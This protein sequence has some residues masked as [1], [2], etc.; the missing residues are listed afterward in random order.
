MPK[1]IFELKCN[2]LINKSLFVH[3]AFGKACVKCKFTCHQIV[4]FW[5]ALIIAINTFFYNEKSQSVHATNVIDMKGIINFYVG[6]N[7]SAQYG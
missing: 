2:D 1:Y 6:S 3:V 5:Y 4:Q 7:V